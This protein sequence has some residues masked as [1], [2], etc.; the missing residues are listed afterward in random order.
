MLHK[1]GKA[2]SFFLLVV[3]TSQVLAQSSVWLATKGNNKVYLGGTIHMLRS[4]DYPLPTEYETA[5]TDADNLYFEIDI[6]QMNDPAAQLGML[7]RL[8]YT[9][10]RTLQTVLDAEAYQSLAD[11]VAK[12]SMPMMMLQNMKP[13]MVMS[14]LE[15]LEFQTRGFTQNGVD[16]H[17]HQRA[18]DDGKLIYAFETVDEQIG[19]IETMGEGEESEYIMLSLR[20]LGKIDSD[21]ESMVSI[22]RNGESEE[23]VDLFVEDMQENTPGVYQSLLLDRN[24][25]WMPTIEAMLDD[26]DTEFVL[27]GVAHLIG[28]DG[29]VQQLR[30]R[31]YQLEQL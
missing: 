29:I 5:Y 13:G 7:Q 20:D 22:W 9:D 17:F 26:A 24:N 16:V 19:F 12:F 2:L 4:S 31:G 1:S 21:I 27:V 30:G 23:L 3:F 14:T 8:M 25:S 10:G 6:D 15:L 11:Y 28:Q 18:K